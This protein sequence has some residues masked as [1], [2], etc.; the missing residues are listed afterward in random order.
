ML[1]DF[2]VVRFM[3]W[4]QTNYMA[5]HDRPVIQEWEDL[6][7]VGDDWEYK[8]GP[9]GS[10]RGMPLDLIL[11]YANEID[12]QPWLNIPHAASDDLI[13]QMV[14]HI[15]ERSNK[16]PI[17]EYSNEVWNGIFTQREYAAE[18]GLALG[19]SG[20]AWE[21]P[22]LYQA[23]RTRLIK[24]VAGDAADVVISG[25]F[26]NPGLADSLLKAA[27][28]HIDAFAIAPYI[29]RNQRA[30]DT[31]LETTRSQD[32]LFLELDDEIQGEMTALFEEY[33]AKTDRYGIE[34]YAY[35]GGLHQSARN[36][37]ADQ[38]LRERETFLAFN[39]SDDARIVTDSLWIQWL[40]SGGTV[41]CPY[42]LCS[43][44]E[45][46]HNGHL[47]AHWFG[48]SELYGNEIRVWPKLEGTT[49]LQKIP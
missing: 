48:H 12:V 15:I 34:L 7:K 36:E 46:K 47:E 29:G 8:G 49:I 11:D 41:A 14:T 5:N 39:R 33:V 18:Q 16:R 28:G 9:W 30:W 2:P 21:A 27:E 23:V 45:H 3:N 32:E 43:V 19:L 24:E 25:Q 13:T 37:S 38:F 20:K 1:T 26:F 6:P 40:I 35:E 4:Q 31:D 22:L 42:S 44:Y 10:F 17:L